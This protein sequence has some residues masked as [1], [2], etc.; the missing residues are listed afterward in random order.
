MCI[1]YGSTQIPYLRTQANHL[2]LQ[3]GVLSKDLPHGRH[4]H[5]YVNCC[6]KHSAYGVLSEF[7]HLF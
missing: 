4:F 2:I 5:G 3:S 1:A 6:D 7:L